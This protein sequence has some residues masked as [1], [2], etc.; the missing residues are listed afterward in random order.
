MAR[1]ASPAPAGFFRASPWLVCCC[2]VPAFGS[3][4]VSSGRVD[5]AQVRHSLCGRLGEMGCGLLGCWSVL[6]ARPVR[7]RGVGWGLKF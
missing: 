3:V 2:P 6:A 4:N 7:G 1:F 5:D